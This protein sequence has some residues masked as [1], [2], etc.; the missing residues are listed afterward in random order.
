MAAVAILRDL[1]LRWR[2]G[3]A[4]SAAARGAREKAIDLYRKALPLAEGPARAMI[5]NRLGVLFYGSSQY[6][7]ACRHYS[8]AI[9]ICPDRFE[10]HVN[11][12]NALDRMDRPDQALASYSRANQLSP[13]NPGL[14]LNMALFHAAAKDYEQSLPLL[15]QALKA[16]SD[17]TGPTASAILAALI[18]VCVAAKKPEVADRELDEALR[19]N[20][21]ERGELLNL[22]AILLSRTDR[23]LEAVALYEEILRTD[24]AFVQAYFNIGMA[25]LRLQAP[26]AALEAF[27]KFAETSPQDPRSEFGLGYAHEN[28]QH[29]D[30]AT[31]HYE[32]FLR[33]ARASTS[34]GLLTEFVNQAQAFLRSRDRLN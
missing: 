6:D 19:A 20:P 3:R 34:D 28:L 2:L 18:Q 32:E 8:Q 29:F 23:A 9:A 25:H 30:L 15:L 10:F 21:S 31:R 17:K 7:E 26:A 4:E 27:R 5:L 1:R 13:G 24:P 33:R 16:R 22:K 12:A 11:L 14:L